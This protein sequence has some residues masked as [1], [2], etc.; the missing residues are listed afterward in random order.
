MAEQGTSRGTLGTVRNAA[1]LLDLLSS[2]PAYQQLT[3][4][5]DRSGLSLPT[6]HRLLRSLIVAGLA[7]QDSESSRYS[8]GPELVRLSESYL[9]RLPVLRALAPYLVQ[10]RNATKA[11]V[12][13]ALLVRGAVV[14]VDRVD[15]EDSG[16]PFRITRRSRSAF[17][18]AAGRVLVA[19]ADAAAWQA[20]VDGHSDLGGHGDEG[21]QGGQGGHGFTDA[22]RA[23]WSSAPYLVV[24][25]DSAL[26]DH[27]EVA[28]PVYDGRGQ[29]LAALA[30]TGTAESFPPDLLAERV[31]PQLL[32]TARAAGA[33]LFPHG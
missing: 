27:P 32:R 11:T 4:L 17:D 25:G 7:E 33:T 28:V 10:V 16:G 5:A 9:G 29:V 1:V 8:L 19:H 18:T 12:L 15:G 31:A 30:A 2:G 6:V 14:Y 13:V 23:S 3:D 26:D 20:A 21:G 24:G 22:D